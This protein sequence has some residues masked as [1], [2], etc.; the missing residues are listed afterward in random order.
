MQMRAGNTRLIMTSLVLAALS[1][2]GWAESPMSVDDASTLA[3]GG[4]K[5]EFGWSK[6]G[7]VKGL[8]GAVGYAPID[9]VEVEVGLARAR[10][11]GV[12]PS[13]ALRVLGAAVKWAPL[14]SETGLSAGLKYEY[15]NTHVSGEGAGH[16]QSLNGLA[17]WAF[18]GGQLLHVNLGREWVRAGG[19]GEAENVWGVG[20]D[21][22]LS[23]A[24]HATIET[25]GAQHSAPDRAVGLR[26]EIQEGV[27]VYAALGRGNDRS[28]S[29]L[30]A[31]WEF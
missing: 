2:T 4:A 15:V 16:G 12:S 9:N 25:Y 7:D 14:Q 8:E 20:L 13:S 26:Y 3:R 21:W 22:P 1:N 18:D 10:D 31:A 28:F 5:V 24:F 6:D 17:T 29:S 27:T 11:F 23:D 19:Q 30:G